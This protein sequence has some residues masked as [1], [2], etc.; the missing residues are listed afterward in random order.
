MRTANQPGQSIPPDLSPFGNWVTALILIITLALIFFGLILVFNGSTFT[1]RGVG[2]MLTMIGVLSWTL[3]N[4]EFSNKPLTAGALYFWN[5]PIM[6]AF[7]FGDEQI[8]VAGRTI[9]W[10]IFP[11]CLSVE[12]FKLTHTNK[13]VPIRVRSINGVILE[14]TANL[15]VRVH[16]H[17]V[18]DFFL[19]GGDLEDVLKQQSDML[20]KRARPLAARKTDQE[21]ISDGNV[22]GAEMARDIQQGSV[23]LLVV[24]LVI[25][26]HQSTAIEEAMQADALEEYQRISSAKDNETLR[27]EAEKM[28]VY[29]NGQATRKE[30][31]D[32]VFQ[33]E[34]KRQ[35]N[36]KQVKTTGGKSHTL[37]TP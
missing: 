8:V 7:G 4:K 11:F 22:I 30:C 10:T 19:A 26:L 5:M 15:T 12:E 9:I 1:G 29:L 16:E 34:L 25:L 28:F 24:T 6:T 18:L 35:G 27:L 37:V 32:L 14:G 17:D 3:G 20:E 36:V 33:A 13:I 21:L 2:L 23:G 31:Y